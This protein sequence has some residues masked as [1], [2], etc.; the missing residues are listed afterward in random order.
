[1]TRKISLSVGKR[2][3]ERSGNYY[4]QGG[5]KKPSNRSLKRPCS[6]CRRLLKGENRGG[7]WEG[8]DEQKGGGASGVASGSPSSWPG[9]KGSQGIPQRFRGGGG[10]QAR[11][12][13]GPAEA[14]EAIRKTVKVYAQC[15]LSGRGRRAEQKIECKKSDGTKWVGLLA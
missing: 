11:R 2:H 10:K 13:A 7:G 12:P 9:P 1:V 6:V 8:G 3:R 4:P 5:E 15:F 14:C